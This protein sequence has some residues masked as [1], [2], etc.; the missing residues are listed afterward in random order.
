MRF[1]CQQFKQSLKDRWKRIFPPEK[2]FMTK[3]ERFN[4][5]EKGALQKFEY[6][7]TK[8]LWLP[9]VL[10][11]QFNRRQCRWLEFATIRYRLVKKN[12]DWSDFVWPNETI[13]DPPVG[14]QMQETIIGIVFRYEPIQWV[15][16]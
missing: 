6:K 5:L 2:Q 13:F 1:N 16:D 10:P 3:R 12:I 11:D 14:R 7:R 4:M 9:K 8:F 15:D